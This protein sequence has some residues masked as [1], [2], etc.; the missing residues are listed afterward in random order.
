MRA[1]A[2]RVTIEPDQRLRGLSRFGGLHAQARYRRQ[3][4]QALDGL[5]QAVGA[6]WLSLD[7]VVGVGDP[8][9]P[10]RAPAAAL[11]ALRDELGA[12]DRMVPPVALEDV[13]LP[14]P[15]LSSD[16]SG[17]CART[18]ERNGCA[19]TASR[20]SPTRPARA[21]PT[22]CACARAR[23]ARARCGG[24]ARPRAEEVRPCSTPAPRS[25][26][27][28]SRSA[29]ARA[30]WA[31]SSRCAAPMDAVIS[32]DL[33]RI[34]HCHEVDMRSLT[35]V[36]GAGLRGPAV[37]S[38]ARPPRPHARP[39][40]AVV[41]VRDARRL[42]R[43]ALGRTGLDRLRQH[44]EAGL[45]AAVRRARRRDRPAA[46]AGDRGRAGLRQSLVGSEGVL[47]VITEATVRV[48]PAAADLALRGLDVPRLRGGRRGLRALEQRHV[49]PD[50]ARLSD[51]AETR[52]DEALPADPSRSP[53]RGRRVHRRARLRGGCL[54]I[55]GFEGTRR[56]STRAA[57]GAAD[58]APCRRP[59]AG[60]LAGPRVAAPALRGPYLRDALL[61]HGILAETLETAAPWSRLMGLY[62]AVGD[63][64]ARALE[65][66][67]T[68][69]LVMCH[70]SHL[71][72][73]GASLYYTF[74]AR[75][76][77]GAEVEQW[78]AVKAAACDAIIAN[79]GTITHHHAIG[80][81]HAAVDAGGGGGA[82]RR[83][84]A[85]V[86]DRARPAGILNPGKLIPGAA[87]RMTRLG[88]PVETACRPRSGSRS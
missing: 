44:R 35:A 88:P 79:G 32:L 19:R 73:D 84:A 65:A 29:V 83:D 11:A 56:T 57:P 38:G 63:A 58:H 14:E 69:G 47:G 4:E 40:P 66:R 54:A 53:A 36:L 50:V 3:L 82:G 39:L 34:D 21:T 86:K 31:A 85:R 9:P 76:Q 10:G 55:L 74:I 27:P 78:Q 7:A 18:W 15:A 8:S 61:D 80:R 41:G 68:P 48:R 22:S 72:P 37:E 6:Q 77:E 52:L 30:W 23:G 24:A 70:I 62:E 1:A 42:G 46:A 49:L 67:G 71:Y 45:R 64:I 2:R 12:P 16:R 5:E 17:G 26:S 13:R 75:Q 81:D 28:W 87:E 25:A 60:R 33:A 43:D 59:G 51:E 20:A